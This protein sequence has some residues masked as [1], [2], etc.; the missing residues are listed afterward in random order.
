MAIG[1]TAVRMFR[2]NSSVTTIRNDQLDPQG[3]EELPERRPNPGRTI[4]GRDDLHAL[5]QSGAELLQLLLERSRDGEDVSVLLH[6]GDAADDLARAVQ[7][8]GAPPLVVPHLD[9]A[10]VLQE[11]RL[12][13]RTATQN[14]KLELVEILGV[15][16]AAQ[17]IV[18]VRH[19]DHAPAGF[20]KDALH[21]RDHLLERH[22]GLGQQRRKNLQLVLLLQ[23][24]HRGHFSHA[25]DGLQSGLDLTLVHL[26]QLTQIVQALPVDQRVLVDPS[27]AAGVGAQGH[28]RVGGQERPDRVDPIEH[29]LPGA[30]PVSGV[31]QDHVDERV[32][33]VRG[34][35]YRLDVR[36][37]DERADQRLCHLPFQQQRASRP[38]DVDD[39]LRIRNI[40]NRVERR[41]TD[42]I[43]A[44][45]DA[46]RHQSPDSG[47]PADDGPNEGGEHRSSEFDPSPSTCVRRR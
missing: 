15:D 11:D 25:W 14:Q 43:G 36:G 20:L 10:D 18:A 35:P 31:A 41:G 37:T 47:S 6:D 8:D 42:G 5:G 40:R 39:D 16:H 19:L 3:F 22:A 30:V 38:L 1:P 2:R 12:A 34:A 46:R 7:V 23:S 24:T 26:A 28:R 32:P 33:H 29:Q 13:V 45:E 4:V 9:V 21:G 17:L 44:Q 27:H